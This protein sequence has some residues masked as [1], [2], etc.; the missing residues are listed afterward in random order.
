MTHIGHALAD[1]LYRVDERTIV[2]NC[3]GLIL[4]GALIL[5]WATLRFLDTIGA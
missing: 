5:G 2:R 4:S 1:H 3:I